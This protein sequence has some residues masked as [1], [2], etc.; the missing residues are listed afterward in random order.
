M[1]SLMTR[2][3]LCVFGLVCVLGSGAAFAQTPAGQGTT[4]TTPNSAPI[5][6]H[7]YVGGAV[8]AGIVDKA[9][10]TG[11]VEAG[12]RIWKS[13]D[14]LVE[15]GYAGD[16]ATRRETDRAA[17]IGAFLSANLG[18]QVSST[19]SV[20]S[21]YLAFGAR[22]VFESTTRYRPYALLSVGGASVDLKPKFVQNGADITGSIGNFGVTLGTDISGKY[23]PLVVGGG[24]GVLVPLGAR[25][26]AD[27]SVRILSV[28]TVDQR[29]NLIRVT[30]GVVRRF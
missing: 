14:V 16:L 29:T 18:S 10:V 23:R 22:W 24:V 26:N 4:S 28:N 20:P 25:W 27:G 21:S 8:G 7:W 3:V 9:S 1:E 12:M 17:T 19:V 13:L 30:I 15:G 5:V 6:H 2:R 11:N